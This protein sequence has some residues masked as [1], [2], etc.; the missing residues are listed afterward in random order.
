[1]MTLYLYGCKYKETYRNNQIFSKKVIVISDFCRSIG[2]SP[3]S[4]V[5]L[6]KHVTLY[7]VNV[8]FADCRPNILCKS[9]NF[10]S[11]IFVNDV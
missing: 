4:I 5:T 1:M 10:L 3:K 9:L 11:C 8:N 6:L 2:I 7:I